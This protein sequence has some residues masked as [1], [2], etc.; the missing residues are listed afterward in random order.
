VKWKCHPSQAS[1]ELVR[2]DTK[3]VVETA[4]MSASEIAEATQ[5]KLPLKQKEEDDKKH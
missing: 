2:L 3:D 5:G 4:T 1:K